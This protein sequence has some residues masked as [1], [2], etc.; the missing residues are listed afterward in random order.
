MPASKLRGHL[1]LESVL[2]GFLFIAG[3][4]AA[5]PSSDQSVDFS[6]A[7]WCPPGY[8]APLQRTTFFSN[9]FPEGSHPKAPVLEVNDFCSNSRAVPDL[10]Q[11]ASCP[12]GEPE[13]TKLANGESAS[14]VCAC[15]AAPWGI[16]RVYRDA[17]PSECDTWHSMT[18]SEKETRTKLLQQRTESMT[19]RLIGSSC[20]VAGAGDKGFS[21]VC[22]TSG[23]YKIGGDERK[24]V[25]SALPEGCGNLRAARF[26]MDG[27]LQE[28]HGFVF[29]CN[30]PDAT[31][32]ARPAS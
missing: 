26:S 11:G 23:P 25:E 3:C 4:A 21:L 15:R 1:V 29:D 16:S 31:S 2:T 13:P 7:D 24:A 18:D 30:V 14:L 8:F 28:D 20:H 12:A 27:Q 10:E 32:P 6:N 17:A 22:S 19:R 5:T 9:L